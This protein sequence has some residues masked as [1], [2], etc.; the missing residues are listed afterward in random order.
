MIPFDSVDYD[1]YM[2][3]SNDL[4]SKKLATVQRREWM[5]KKLPTKIK[6]IKVPLVPTFKII[7][8][9]FSNTTYL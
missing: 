4:L 8:F 1:A 7:M 6:M 9:L 3:V 5:G 2:E